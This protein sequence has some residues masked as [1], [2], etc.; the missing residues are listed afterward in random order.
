MHPD[1]LKN[2]LQENHS[3]SH[4]IN[5]DL[6]I[7]VCHSAAGYYI[8]MNDTDGTPHARFSQ[9]YWATEAEAQAAYDTGVYNFKLW[10]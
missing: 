3:A 1:L 7:G 9:E 5:W 6:P 2:Y 8:G 4:Y 10:P